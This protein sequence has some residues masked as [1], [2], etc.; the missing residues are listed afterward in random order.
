MPTA[1]GMIVGYN[2]QMAVDARH[3]LIAAADVT[4]DVTDY[5]QL[6]GVAL[7]AQANW[8]WRRPKWWPTRATTTRPK[9]AGVKNTASRPTFPRATPAP[10]RRGALWQEPIPV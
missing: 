10:T 2:A 7:E 8:N 6:A 3:K 1:H 5:Q 4:N 9:S